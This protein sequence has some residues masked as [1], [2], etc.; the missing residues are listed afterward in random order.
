MDSV[1][2]ATARQEH[3]PHSEHQHH[4][5]HHHHQYNPK[6]E[7]VDSLRVATACQERATGWEGEGEYGGSPVFHNYMIIAMNHT[8]NCNMI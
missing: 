2:V 3:Q 6:P 8:N 7:D 1:Y 4:H 5:Y